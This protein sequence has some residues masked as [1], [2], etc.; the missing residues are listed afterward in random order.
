MGASD[1]CGSML[2]PEGLPLVSGKG[3]VDDEEV[4][5]WL[6]AGTCVNFV[7]NKNLTVVVKRLL[8]P[9][10]NKVVWNF[11]SRGLT[12]VGQDDVAILLELKEDEQIPPRDVFTMLQS[13]YEQS[14]AGHPVQEM[15]H[16]AVT[17]DF[18]DSNVH[19]GWLFIRHT[20]QTVSD[21]LL[22]A[23]PLLFAILLNKW[24]VPW[25]RVFPLRLMLRLGAESRYYPAPLVSIRGR[26]S[27]YGEIGHTIMNVLADF[28]NYAYS[29]PTIRGFVINMS[30]GR[31]S[32]LLPKNRYDGVVKALNNSNDPVLALGANFSMSADSHLVAIQGEDGSY[33]TQAINILNKERKVTGASFVVF[34]GAL[35]SASGLTAKSSIV[36]D[37]LMVQVSPDRMVEIR[38]ALRNMED[39][40][41][42][43]G[44]VGAD[45][46]DEVVAIQWVD[47][48]KAF[49]IGIKSV[50]DGRAMDGVSS[51]RIHSGPDMMGDKHLIR[52]TEVFLINTGEAGTPPPGDPPDPARASEGVARATCIAL[53]PHLNQ[54]KMDDL[55][56]VGVRVVLDQD[57]VGYEAGAGG[58]ALPPLYMNSLDNELIPVLHA[59]AAGPGT[60]FTLELVFH[61]LDH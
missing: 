36:E 16:V 9:P 40:E 27:V 24:E 13:L 22:P 33:Q 58:V 42:G 44:P 18:L 20:F 15:G 37:G 46:P 45:K 11:A 53:L 61:I 51:L 12:S 8:Y 56:P 29:L 34:N 4:A 41:I 38:N 17:Q 60:A 25:A 23:P 1:V 57:K 2:P 6:A 32:L 31:T 10:V 7:L 43:C 3:K 19:G 55:T 39:H 14:G 30:P 47:E 5:V 54:L 52:W 59:G 26:K 50:I 28:R 49:N 35:K 48:D 21:L